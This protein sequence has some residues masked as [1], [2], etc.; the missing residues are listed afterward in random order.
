MTYIDNLAHASSRIDDLERERDSLREDLNYMKSQSMRN[1]LIFTGVPDVES[2]SPD[3]QESIL[4]KNILQMRLK[5]Q[6]KRWHVS[7]SR[8]S[9]DRRGN[10]RV[11]KLAL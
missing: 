11:V 2:E 3:T 6:M 1:N 7:C 9:T 8:G 5:S 4:K 10:K